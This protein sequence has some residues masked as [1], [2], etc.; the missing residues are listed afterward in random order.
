[1]K[2][3]WN[4]DEETA[5]VLSSDG[6]LRTGDIATMDGDGFFRIVDRKKDLILVS[7]FNVYPNEI[8]EVVAG[9]PG[10]LEAGAIGVPDP[11][12]DEAVKLIVVRKQPDLTKESV[13]EYCKEH[14]TSYK[15]PKYVEFC[16][17]LPKTNV[18]KILRRALREVYGSV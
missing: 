2:G 12:T 7:G 1:M 15:V 8:E 5:M 13:R 18:G 3:Y 6:W 11:K 17:E 16:N 9:H 10:I 14:L 4:K